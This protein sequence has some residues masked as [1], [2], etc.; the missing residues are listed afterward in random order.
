MKIEI[1]KN[2]KMWLG[3][4]LVLVVVSLVALF[5]IKLNYGIDFTGG[6]LYQLKF[7]KVVELKELNTILDSM[8]TQFEELN[9]RKVQIS[10]ENTVIIRTAAMDET[11]QMAFKSELKNKYSS[12]VVEKAEKVGSVIGTELK[13][14]AINALIIASILI[15][16]YITIRFEFRFAVAAIIALLHDVIISVGIIA[17]IGY[18]VNTPFIAAMLTILG[19]SINDTL[20]VFDRIRE[21]MKG[22]EK[23]ENLGE[24][25]MGEVIDKSI[26]QVMVRSINTS[27]TTLLAILA[28]L[29]FGGASLKTFIMTLL[30]GIVSG[31][32]SSIFVASPIVFLLEKRVKPDA[33]V[34]VKKA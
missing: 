22:G 28:I 33:K 15:I 7:D 6:N 29:I 16:L 2:T 24:E 11:K 3:I 9:S 26:N 20:V 19:Y 30:V 27:V 14:K 8:G 34:E 1:I 21:N 17:M 4:S 25:K 13:R 31:T 32:Y 18:E 10:G 5:G 12:F 23:L